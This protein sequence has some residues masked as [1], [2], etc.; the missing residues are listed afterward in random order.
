[1]TEKKGTISGK[2]VESADKK[3]KGT[4]KEQKENK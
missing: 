4:V 1:M 3:I 2:V